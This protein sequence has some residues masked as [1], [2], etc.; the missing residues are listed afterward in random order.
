MCGGHVRVV[1]CFWSCGVTRPDPVA[2][3][4]WS[5]L[6]LEGK[7]SY[8]HYAGLQ[9]LGTQQ[10]GNSTASCITKCATYPQAPHALP[11]KNRTPCTHARTCNPP[12]SHALAL[13]PKTDADPCP[14]SACTTRVLCSNAYS[15]ITFDLRHYADWFYGKTTGAAVRAR[16]SK[17]KT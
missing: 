10:I 15:N 16:G 1:M 8:Q 9:T 11:P 12:P 13:P 7:T 14:A 17:F 4:P 6:E 3:C 2:G 5:T